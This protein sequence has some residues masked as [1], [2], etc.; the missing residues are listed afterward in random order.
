MWDDL[1]S[2][3]T[4][5]DVVELP[6]EVYLCAAGRAMFTFDYVNREVSK[7]SK[8]NGLNDVN[9]TAIE[10]DPLSGRVVVGYQNANIDLLDGD[11]IINVSDIL[12]SEKFSGRKRINEIYIRNG[13]AYLATGFGVVELRIESQLILDT[14]VI[15]PNNTEIEVYDIVFDDA[16]DTVWAATEDGLYKAYQYDPLYYYQSWEKDER[17]D[18]EVNGQIDVLNGVLFTA[19]NGENNLDTLWMMSDGLGWI[20]APDVSAGELTSLD[21]VDNELFT[22]F[23]YTAEVRD[24]TGAIQQLIS[25][26][27]GGNA[28]FRPQCALRK[29]NGNW[30]IGDGVSGLI[31][32][33]NPSY[34]QKALPSSPHSNNVYSVY[35]CSSGLYIAPGNVNGVW[36]PTFNYNGF[37]RYHNDAWDNYGR[38]RTDTAHDILQVLE[39]PIDPTRVFVASMGSGILE[40]RDGELYEKWDVESTGGVIKGTSSD[41]DVRTGGMAFDAEGVLW[42]TSSES[43]ASLLSYNRE[44]DWE[45]HS[46]GSFNGKDLKNIR[47]LE[48]GDFW[49]QGR[50]DGIYAVHME[51]GVTRVRQLTTGEGNGDLSSSFVHDFE[52]DLDGEVWIGTGEGVMVHYSPSGLFSSSGYYDA[53]SILI[54]ENGVYQRLLGS[55]GVSAIE[56]D[57]S[58]RKWFGTETGGVF[59][60]SEDGLDEIYHFTR[61]N[62]PLPSNYIVD[63]EVDGETGVVYIATDMGVVTFNGSATAGVEEMTDVTVYPNPVRPGYTGEIAIRGLVTDAQV[64]IT[65]VSGNIVFETVA[66]GGQAIWSGY[67][68][69]GNRV[70]SG[71]YLAYITDDLGE[72]THVAKILVIKGN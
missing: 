70:S 58:N 67:D 18:R 68:L 32:V 65:D 66:N 19:S 39:D 60:T 34:V 25:P 9:V 26:G 15:G 30:F 47:I 57:G 50:N 41:N 44:G 27:Y 5:T 51:D 17:F 22:C 69:S 31:F 23:T 55:E 40:Y 54:L 21:V 7:F 20:K 12:D 63:V 3:R 14:W 61:N 33:N 59:Y 52:Q 37:Y 35:N 28:T 36:A 53:Q 6:N 16:H 49:L 29:S 56:I 71:V 4:V 2:Y 42:V 72:N 38:G 64:K 48:N 24:E 45:S 62:S 10:R 11:Q 46:I 1:Y 43:D 13:M 8:A